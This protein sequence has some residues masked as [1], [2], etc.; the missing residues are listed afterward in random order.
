MTSNLGG[1]HVGTLSDGR[2]KVVVW[3]FIW[4]DNEAHYE[5][6]RYEL[7]FYGVNPRTKRL[8]LIQRQRSA[9]KYDEIDRGKGAA[10]EFG[11]QVHN[12]LDDIPEFKAFVSPD[13]RDEE[14]EPS[15]QT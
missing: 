7:E 3:D 1:F 5:P 6:H 12:L 11:L 10:R 14:D 8:F 15:H 13:E 4:A 9:K 2:I